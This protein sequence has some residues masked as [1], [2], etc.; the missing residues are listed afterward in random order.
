MLITIFVFYAFVI[1]V[2]NYS[3]ISV[4]SIVCYFVCLTV[5]AVLYAWC[6]YFE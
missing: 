2:L 1:N 3:K 4:L 6:L 5:F